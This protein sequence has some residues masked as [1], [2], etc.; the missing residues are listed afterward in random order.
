MALKQHLQSP[1]P[2]LLLFEDVISQA[3]GLFIFI[4]TV[5]LVLE[6]CEDPTESLEATLQDSDDTGLISPYG[7][8]SSI[9]K[10]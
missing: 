5:A 1:W 10:T 3:A 8:Y 6:K 9:L 7:L 2:E 4:K